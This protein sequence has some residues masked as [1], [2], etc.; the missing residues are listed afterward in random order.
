MSRYLVIPIDVA[1][2]AV[3]G[4]TL[5]NNT[6][7][8]P[9]MTSFDQLPYGG[10][11]SQQPFISE[12][13]IAQPFNGASASGQPGVYLHW[14]MP[15]AL[16]RGTRPV[17]AQGQPIPGSSPE[18]PALPDRWLVTR[19][20]L[21][22]GS[23]VAVRSWVVDSRYLAL[24][25]S[26]QTGNIGS[27]AIP[28]QT[29]NDPNWQQQPYRYLGRAVP[30][31]TWSAASAPAA[32]YLP[33]LNATSFGMIELAAY[34]P[35]TQNVF[36]FYDPLTDLGSPQAVELCYAVTGWHTRS[37][38]DPLAGKTPDE[39][40]QKLNN[41]KWQLPN[42]GA[43][44]GTAYCGVVNS[45][46]WSQNL[47]PVQPSPL[48]ATI[49]NTTTEALSALIVNS[50]PPALEQD[51]EPEDELEFQLHTLLS[52]QLALLGEQ[53][54]TK[55]VT[56]QLHQQRFSPIPGNSVWY[57]RRKQDGADLS[58]SLSPALSA[59]L[60]QLNALQTTADN[61]RNQIRAKQWQVFADW[62]KY[63]IC[64]YWPTNDPPV[65]PEDVMA[66]LQG[67]AGQGTDPHAPLPDLENDLA[68]L[69]PAQQ[70]VDAARNQLLAGINLTN[71]AGLVELA[72]K[73]GEMFWRPADPTLLLSG[74]DIT[75]ALRYGG[76]GLNSA[77][78]TLACRTSDRLVNQLN[79]P[80]GAV[81][82]APA[83]S[84]TA[85]DSPGLGAGGSGSG[86]DPG[87]VSLA[88]NFV[89]ESV[90]LWPNWAA[91]MLAGKPGG[92]GAQAQPAWQTWVKQQEN[93]FLAAGSSSTVYAG[94]PPSP[95]G[96]DVWA[97]NPWLPIMMH[98]QLSYW[99]AQLIPQDAP[100]QSL[101]PGL[102]MSRLHPGNDSL[103]AEGV[104]LVLTGSRGANVTQYQGITFIT[105]HAG[106]AAWQQLQAYAK[107][108]PNSPLGKL[109][110]QVAPMPLLS[111][112]LAGFHDR[113]LL[114]RQTLQLD[115]ADPFC[116]DD[117]CDFIQRVRQDVTRFGS[118][119]NTLAPMVQDAFC[120]VRAGLLDLATLWLV[121]VFGQ[122]RAYQFGPGANQVA[123]SRS[124]SATNMFAT[125]STAPVFLPPRLSQPAAL[126]FQ[127]L[128]ATSDSVVTGTQL[129][130]S[131]ICGWLVPNYLDGSLMIY[132]ASGVALGS[133][134][135]IAGRIAWLGSPANPSAF[136]QTP[137]QA[138]QN[139]NTHLWAFVQ[140]LLARSDPQY[141]V[142]FLNTLN[143]ASATIQPL[144]FAQS[145][146]LPVL[147]GQPLALVRASLALGFMSGP[148]INNTWQAFR[149]NVDSQSASRTTNGHEAVNFPVLLGSVDDPDD[150]L[151]GFYLDA[152]QSPFSTFYSVVPAQGSGIATRQIQTVNLSVAGSPIALTM[153]ID[154]RCHVHAT[155][156]YM[157]AQAVQIPPEMF[158]DA[159]AKMAVTFLTA[160]VL[161]AVP[162]AGIAHPPVALPLPLPGQQ[163][164]QWSWVSV[165]LE[166]NAQQATVS[167]T[168]A[169]KP[170]QPFSQPSFNLQEGW[171]S[172]QDFEE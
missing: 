119:A 97:G 45:V 106:Y 149:Q 43:L 125:Q 4:Q 102:I 46:M 140:A 17:D 121:D 144:G 75:P 54:G 113:F 6:G 15:D 95:V 88:A 8:A 131:P 117:V 130:S 96:I 36:G 172:L 9:A 64:A 169:L 157:P 92:G 93:A 160:P 161:T 116:L 66:Y 38:D 103:D 112:S 143:D 48:S 44:D 69:R 1:A 147:V 61:L 3:T 137:Q 164:G 100:Q 49:A 25:V 107:T 111:Q 120:P 171:L 87:I 26:A 114:R 104:D 13:V 12:A 37:A 167:P 80:Q 101:D 33:S 94:T 141:L 122:Y 18:F 71:L 32:G 72:P 21:V 118:R 138:F 134:T 60:D 163:K 34:Y 166:D 50:A 133:V 23:P 150:G 73:P 29:P 105:P 74:K 65:D 16:M 42:P 152:S 30:L 70:A 128:A 142:N 62:Y 79:A 110:S 59:L 58:A 135:Q 84:L 68:A 63:A 52:G 28:W 146:Q 170:D 168:V 158:R 77:D 24:N 10:R 11:T 85:Q 139:Q 123:A 136:N 91:A 90:L 47:P 57:A 159:F 98:W 31:E 56:R 19:L 41:L 148:A 35:N 89:L 99:P 151:V 27:S 165:V 82:G 51:L 109:A 14:A 78:G 115:V 76:D 127:W 40:T 156:G 55:M 126:R 83:L 108:H 81:Q 2:L 132:D 145:A 162:P 22:S 86:L 53:T 154:P 155:T 153:I 124:L 5:P 39:V 129:S 7:F 67:T 20:A